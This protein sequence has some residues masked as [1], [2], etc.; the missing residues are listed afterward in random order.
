M[1]CCCEDTVVGRYH[2]SWTEL[3]LL[4]RLAE[5]DGGCELDG[6]GRAQ[7]IVAHERHGALDD[8]FFHPQQQIRAS[9]VYKERTKQVITFE[10]THMPYGVFCL[11]RTATGA[12]LHPASVRM[13]ARRT[14][15]G[16]VGE[17]R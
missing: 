6:I 7:R 4:E 14:E 16:S 9:A 17:R 15:G 3:C 8:I 12:T 11:E 10:S 1:R 13:P 5:L 2:D